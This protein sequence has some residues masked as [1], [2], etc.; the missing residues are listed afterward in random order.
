MLDYFGRTAEGRPSQHTL[1]NT[2][3]RVY[4]VVEFDFAE[5]GRDGKTPSRWA[6]LIREWRSQ[7]RSLADACAA[8]HLHL[9]ELIPLV[10]V[11]HSGGKSLH[12]WYYV[13]DRREAELR[14]FK[15]Y[16]VSLGADR[17]T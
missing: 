15:E 3:R 10:C 4:L 6:S 11:T 16:A 9:G 2:A 1:A 5:F 7:D 14:H 17:A 12:G 13:F 8:I